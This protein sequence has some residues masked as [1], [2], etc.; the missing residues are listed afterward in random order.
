LLDSKD[1]RLKP[2]ERE[3]LE[4]IADRLRRSDYAPGR[5]GQGWIP[6]TRDTLPSAYRQ[7]IEEAFGFDGDLSNRGQGVGDD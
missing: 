5:P 1:T 4:Q 2:R 6:P 7:A 3:L